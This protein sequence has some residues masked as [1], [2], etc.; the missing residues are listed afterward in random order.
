MLS[1]IVRGGS[2]RAN[3][4]TASPGR[5]FAA[6]ELKLIMAHII[7]NYDLKLEDPSAPR[8]HIT[9]WHTLFP[10]PAVRVLFKK[11]QDVSAVCCQE[12]TD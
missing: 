7:L 2:G 1:A 11:R 8:D 9:R 10:S 3:R 6:N 4:W 5:F 12:G